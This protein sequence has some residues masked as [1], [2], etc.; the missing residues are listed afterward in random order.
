MIF[1][2]IFPVLAGVSIVLQGTLNRQIA[3][4][5]GLVS[6][7]FLNALVFL[8]FSGI[9]WL[10]VRYELISG[11]PILSAKP[12][13]GLSWWDVLPGLFGFLIVFSTPLAISF[14]GANLTFA[15]IICT[16]LAV[17]ILWDSISNRQ[18]PSVSTLVGVGV[19]LIGLAI[20][21]LGRK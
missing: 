2:F 3:G 1:K 7:V 16:Q 21:S 19:M 13:M 10:L 20:L 15:M 5:I 17:S 11:I 9:L 6:A 4:Q 18:A 14:L 8:V 12:L